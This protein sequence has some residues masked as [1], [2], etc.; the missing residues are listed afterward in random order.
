MSSKTRAI[1]SIQVEL[2]QATELSFADLYEWVL[3]QFPRLKGGWLLGAAHPPQ[4]AY[5]WI[6]VRIQPLKQR[7]QLFAHNVEP[8]PS[9]E[10]AVSWLDENTNA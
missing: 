1:G 4:A 5:G 2:E 9:P 10:E 7:V 8:L 6:P 3:W